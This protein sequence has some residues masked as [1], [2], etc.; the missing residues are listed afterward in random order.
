MIK[1]RLKPV[2]TIDNREAKQAKK[3]E[4]WITIHNRRA[5]FYCWSWMFQMLLVEVWVKWMEGINQASS[6][7]LMVGEVA[8]N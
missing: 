4:F 6:G 2:E 8:F 7:K 1:Y 3:M 5:E